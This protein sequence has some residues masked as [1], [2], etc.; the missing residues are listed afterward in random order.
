MDL[1]ITRAGGFLLDPDRSDFKIVSGT[2][3]VSQYVWTV[4]NT[5]QRNKIIDGANIPGFIGMIN[6]EDNG[7]RIQ[8]T[9]ESALNRGLNGMASIAFSVDVYPTSKS[10]VRVP[11]FATVAGV[12]YPASIIEFSY[13]QGIQDNIQ[14]VISTSPPQHTRVSNPILKRNF[15]N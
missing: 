5:E 2:D 1:G 15:R 3:F 14:P 4:A 9:M 7:K 11:I 6:N 12:Q 8:R 10:T 13:T